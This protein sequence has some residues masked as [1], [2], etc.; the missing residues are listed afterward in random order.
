MAMGQGEQRAIH[1]FFRKGHYDFSTISEHVLIDADFGVSKPV[2]QPVDI[3]LL[4]PTTSPESNSNG[5]PT[6]QSPPVAALDHDPNSDRRKRRKTSRDAD[7]AS[8]VDA[9]TEGEPI[10]EGSDLAEDGTTIAIAETPST[11]YAVQVPALPQ[12]S[13]PLQSVT[14][15]SDY[16]PVD[17]G[18]KKQ[19]VVKLNANGKL[20]SSP[21]AN[22]FADM[23][24]RKSSRRGRPP[25]RLTED[26]EKKLVVI[27]YINQDGHSQSIGQ[28][29][30]EILS[31]RRKHTT[32]N[33]PARPTTTIPAA[34][35]RQPPKATHPFFLK[36]AAQKPDVS[37]TDPPPQDL[38]STPAD[39]NVTSKPNPALLPPFSKPALSF[40]HVFAK[41]PDPVHP[42]WPP[43]G[44]THVRDLNH[45]Y[46][47]GDDRQTFETDT[48]KSKTPAVQVSDE[49]SVLAS[50]KSS[51]NVD[52][53]LR[54]PRQQ[55]ISGRVLQ[56]NIA[57]R[58]T[59]QRAASD[60]GETPAYDAFHPAVAKLY[61][62]LPTSLS[63]FDRGDYEA[64]IWAHKYAPTSAQQVLCATKEALMLRDWLNHLVVSNVEMG[65]PSKDNERAKRKEEKKRKRR[66]KADKLDGFV[67]DSEDEYSE[68]GEISGSDDEL[69]GDVTTVSSK[70][71]VIRTGDLTFSLRSNNERGRMTNAILLSG[72]S[73]CGKTASV[74]AVAKEMDF[75]VFEINAG[76]RRSAKDIL[77]R[78]GDMT[79]NHLVHN[80]HDKENRNQASGTESQ[81]DEL[82]DAKQNKLKG[83]FKSAST[84]KK[85]GRPKSKASA[86]EST[87]QARS[88]KQSLILLEEADIL[89]EEDK[90]FWSGVL[91]L[92]NQSKRP[93]V[94]T[95]NDESLVPL[96]DIS[97]HAI[98][99]YRA[100]SQELAVDYLLLMAANEG[101]IL[102]RTAIEKLYSST[103]NDLRK[104]IMD[105]NYWCQ[106][107]VGSEKSGLDWMIDRWPQGIDLDSNGDKMRVLSMDTYDDYMG[108]FSRDVSISPGLTTE[109]E[110]REEAL[111]WWQLSLQEADDME[112]MQRRPFSEQ[113]SGMS[114][115]ELLENLHHQ[116][117]YA[118][119]RSVLDV[120]TASCS[121]DAKKDAIDTSVPP[122]CEKQKLNFV[123]GYHLLQA[124][125]V[126]D[127]T[128]LTLDVGSTF[129]ALVG[130]AFRRM[131][132]ADLKD[133]LATNLFEAVSK[134]KAAQSHDKELLDALMPAMKPDCETLP[135]SGSAELAFEYGQRSIAEDVTPY[136]RSIVAFDLRLE[137]YRREL[138]GLLSGNGR[139]TKRM[140][141][142]RASRAALEGGNKA[143]TR[144]ERWFSSALNVQ[145]ILATGNKEWQDLLVQNGY[146][147]V[148]VAGEQ[149]VGDD[150]LSPRSATT[151]TSS[152]Q[153]T[154]V[155]L[156]LS[157]QG[158]Q[159]FSLK[160]FSIFGLR[161]SQSPSGQIEIGTINP[162]QA[163]LVRKSF[164][165]SLITSDRAPSLASFL[166][167]T[168]HRS[169]SMSLFGTSPD[170]SP[171]A[172]S[173]RRSKSS[174]FADEASFGTGG[175]NF[176]SSSLFADDDS[177][178]SPWS[179]NTGKRTSK[180]QL[181]KSLLP[182]SDVPESYVD[183]Y[184]LVLSA[185]ERAGTGVGLTTVREL[186]S[187]GGLSATDQAK[188]LNLVLSG[189]TDRHNGLGRGEFNV[190]LALIGLAQEGEDLTFD[191]VDDRQL[192]VPKSSYL[193]GLRAKQ[194][195][196]MSPSHEHPRTPPAPSGPVQ[197]PSPSQSRR[198]RGDS[199]GGLD[200]DPWGSPQLH[201]G[202]AHAQNESERG[203]LNGYG[204]ARS[205][206]NAW[207]KTGDSGNP[208]EPS[209]TARTNGRP[210]A[211]SSNSAE[212]GW[213][214]HFPQSSDGSG[215]GGPVRPNLGDFG[216]SGSGHGGSNSGRRSLN[217]DRAIN[218]HVKEVVTVTLL[219][220]KEGL[221]M[222][223]HRNYEVKSARRGSTVVRRYS[224]FVWLLDCLHKRYPFR[225]LPL[226]PPKRIA[227]NGTHLSADS[228]S[229]LEK[230]RRGL[231]RFTNSLVS[232]PV[233]SQEQLVVMFLTVPTELSV[234]R[235]QA[236]ISVQDEFA[237][238]VL[239]PDL[240][241][242]L[243][244][245]LIDTFDT[246]RS[247]VKRS[248][249]VYINLCT[250]LERLAKRNEGL[251]ADHLRFSLALQSLTE[252]TRDTY[253]IDTNDVPL[254]NEGIKATARH[255]SASQSLLEDEARAWEDGMLEDLKRQ[256]DNLVSVREMFD[257][258]DR[259]A[260]NNIPQL[261]KRI[262]TNERKLQD[263][264]ARPQ[265]TV[266]PGEIEKV[267]E[268][269]FKDKESI[270]QQHARGVFIKEC[271]R[272]ELIYFQQTQYHISR[273]HQDWSQE[274]V[275]YS[276]LQADN[277]RSLGDQVE[278]MPLG[279]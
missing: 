263:L 64:Q 66:K 224:D 6:L 273:L 127:Y 77:D 240:E 215:L 22:K 205:A 106:M 107:A 94:I 32:S 99:R 197:E 2:V 176:G 1:A 102:E 216:R 20:L 110:L 191:T 233:L 209:D 162:P 271:I 222:F 153:S 45:S 108:W 228:N 123:E 140:R 235:K 177:L 189:D 56:A 12:G 214:D 89:F 143:E 227:V 207:S 131:D 54:E 51:A 272:D 11:S 114:K 231:V 247:G 74:Y 112:D 86:K 185:G 198:A 206:T 248:A 82:E 31:G 255:L 132:E 9:V 266:K 163:R 136:V 67:V 146:F 139:G 101:H 81:V 38:P 75:E 267:E 236:T 109:I 36:K 43:S 156:S 41:V 4:R 257:R 73:G 60:T 39:E 208:A 212:F 175:A 167:R 190:L 63:A 69:A 174:L 220:E 279:D 213:G 119:S 130:R 193:D 154:R 118:E 55:V 181:V 157:S 172:D 24:K 128:T 28:Q 80:L 238:R 253:A 210:E 65:N 269:I 144:R 245:T 201:R 125:H 182:D 166:H 35:T 179:N 115:L 26:V 19:R 169:S 186:L 92:I 122:I 117:E 85:P 221:F 88:Q 17:P 40:K 219:Q 158:K 151:S 204:S 87:V 49:E 250:L 161:Y 25:A 105:L 96:D 229:F 195:S 249:E 148:P 211:R 83:F 15:S 164:C 23:S 152:P 142:T 244:S 16:T 116:S 187:G 5:S 100:P 243:P 270:V 237:G 93:I 192:P 134:P 264:R 30:N 196:A 57:K 104:S 91:T 180:Q 61:A 34:T 13:E 274:R 149:A 239:P 183:A 37:S 223:Q 246:V 7:N 242:S 260:R 62:S 258:R 225:Q 27:K 71:T 241:D 194:E 138:S 133:M 79:Q 141:T 10:H 226:L 184:D 98:L 137:N 259:L 171:A 256:R 72:P 113:S 234:W 251:A 42:L 58:L 200:A 111:H 265:G 202:H 97:F 21:V 33:H 230:R 276:E 18:E 232:H 68:M 275:K 126:P 8:V 53:A 76:S 262:E 121:L 147:T 277:W 254:L 78:I 159:V 145:R 155:T 278:G 50:I 14:G 160:P 203:M 29:I 150:I 84:A 124:D 3:G 129:Q 46:D 178:G 48:R 173:A 95:C 261:E 252:M 52:R 218:N 268:S 168:A 59:G 90:Q 120:L 170:D 199:M 70:R 165:P 217:I 135:P 188:I 47:S 103:G 44:L